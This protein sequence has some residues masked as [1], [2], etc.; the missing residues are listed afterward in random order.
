MWWFSL[1]ATVFSF[2]SP[3]PV[4]EQKNARKPQ[5]EVRFAISCVTLGLVFSNVCTAYMHF[6]WLM[7]ISCNYTTVWPF[8]KFS[9]VS[10]WS[11]KVSQEICWSCIFY[12]A[13]V[14]VLYGTQ[15]TVYCRSTE[16]RFVITITFTCLDFLRRTSASRSLSRGINIVYDTAFLKTC[17]LCWLPGLCD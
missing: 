9:W 10:Q 14:L 3:V 12:T 8:S 17:Q 2:L 15:L 1:I 6:T 11:L 5:I 4:Q 7:V 16:C 13:D